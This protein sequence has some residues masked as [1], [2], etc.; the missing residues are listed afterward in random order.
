MMQLSS[1]KSSVAKN[2]YYKDMY[3]FVKFASHLHK[4]GPWHI[5]LL[6]T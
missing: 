3:P 4:S 2:D 5:T 1:L 6:C